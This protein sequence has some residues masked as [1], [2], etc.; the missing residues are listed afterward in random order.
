MTGCYVYVWVR[1]IQSWSF[2]QESAFLVLQNSKIKFPLTSRV[3]RKLHKPRFTTTRPRL[4]Y[5]MT[6]NTE[7]DP[8]TNMHEV[9][10]S[11]QARLRD[12]SVTKM[13]G[14]GFVR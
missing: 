2:G 6:N 3:T 9:I 14:D 11:E 5:S 13:C 8:L 1:T 12:N 7:I 10:T 4:F